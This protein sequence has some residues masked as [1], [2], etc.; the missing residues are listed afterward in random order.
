ML[1]LVG[2]DGHNVGVAG[3]DV[4]GHEHGVEEEAHAGGEAAVDLVFVGVGPVEEPFAGGGSEEPGELADL[5]HIA[6]AEEGGAV[7]VEA[8]REVGCGGLGGESVERSRVVDGVEGVVVCEEVEGV[9]LRLD[10]LADGA[11]VVAEVEVAV[12]LDAGEV[13]FVHGSGG[14]LGAAVCGSS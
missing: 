13:S 1:H 3:E 10:V 8:E 5:G 2:A 9:V 7:G 4:C 11:E 12:G 6:L 14:E